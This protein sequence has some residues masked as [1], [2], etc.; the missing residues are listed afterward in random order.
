MEQEKRGTVLRTGLSVEDRESVY[1]SCTEEGWVFHGLC[2]SLNQHVMSDITVGRRSRSI[3]G[4]IY[5][6]DYNQVDPAWLCRGASP[7]SALF[8][9]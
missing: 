3:S 8:E 4:V 7:E 9:R 2:V 1:L 6:L 5:A